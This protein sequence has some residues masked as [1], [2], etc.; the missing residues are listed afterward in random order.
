MNRKPLAEIIDETIRAESIRLP[1]HPEVARRFREL[2][3]TGTPQP[4]ALAELASSDPALACNLFHAA[5]SSFYKGLQKAVT[6]AETITRIGVETTIETLERACREGTPDGR[7]QLA[8]RY[9]PQLW[10]HSIG[11]ALGAHWLA[12]R[13][14]YQA[15]AEQARLAGLLHDIGKLFLLATLEEVSTSGED[16]LTLPDQL[17]EE[18]LETMHVEQGMKLFKRWNLPD[19]F[20]AAIG[21]HHDTGGEKQDSIVA[22][23]RLANKGCHKLGLGWETDSSMILPTTAEAQFLGID[24]ISL[25]EYEIMLEDRFGLARTRS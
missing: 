18:V 7:L 20:A 15:L 10:Q 4:E 11:C 22:L 1:V 8:S 3:A 14:G 12:C 19:E 17:V 21:Q 24:E 23:V 16:P 6:I 13:C 9:L 25:A 5:N 2:V